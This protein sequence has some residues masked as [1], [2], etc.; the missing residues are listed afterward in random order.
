ME[1]P[2]HRRYPCLLTTYWLL[3]YLRRGPPI[4]LYGPKCELNVKDLLT[5]LIAINY[6][7]SDY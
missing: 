2:L 4:R 7:E 1:I 6:S 5:F 3:S